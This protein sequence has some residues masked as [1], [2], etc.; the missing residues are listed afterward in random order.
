[1]KSRTKNLI[2]HQKIGELVK[3][4]FGQ[5]YEVS[6]IEELT[7][8]M[9]SA[10]YRIEGTGGPDQLILKV[11]PP[12]E[13]PLLSY[14]QTVMATE[15]ECLRLIRERT[16]VPVPKVLAYDFSKTALDS[17]YFFMTALEGVT[18]NCVSK[19][20]SRD[21]LSRLKIELGEYLAQLHQIKGPYYGYFT[22]A[23]ARQFSTWKDAFF[24]M[25]DQLLRDGQERKAR[26][27]YAKI[28]SALSKY[29][30]YLEDAAETPALVDFDCHDGNIF[31]KQVD[32][33]Y[34]I[35]GIADLE[36]AFW[37]D[38]IADFAAAFFQ[39]DDISREPDFICSYMIAMN[40]TNYSNEDAA[41]FLLYRLYLMA[42]MAVETF[43]YEPLYAMAQG[44]WARWN[45]VKCLRKLARRKSGPT[46]WQRIQ[47]W[48]QSSIIVLPSSE[49]R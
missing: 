22:Q 47:F 13:A 46:L 27:P 30:G 12:P 44:T 28:R 9:F 19:S 6:R 49:R 10:V 15:V 37:G 29:E 21:N 32:G 5:A 40:K 39:T 2:S 41:R 31:V 14:E 23:P 25:F 45:I 4:H 18:L 35:V 43:R 26:L 8:G 7:G 38:P 1:M 42:V 20:M 17:D 48:K 36:R 34:Q 33:I 24:H 16:S 3:L 11:G